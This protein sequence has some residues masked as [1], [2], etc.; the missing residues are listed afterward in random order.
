MARMIPPRILPDCSSLG[1]QEIFRRLKDDP[2][3]N[4][5]IVLHSLDVA[6]HMTSIA[7]EIDF[8]AIVPGKGVLCV[9]VKGCKSLRRHDGLWY[10]GKAPS[11]DARG[12]FKQASTAMHSIR[13]KLAK[14]RRTW[15]KFHFGRQ[16]FSLT[17]NSRMSP[18]SGIGGK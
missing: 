10:Y 5:W 15:G 16:L 9:E 12:P 18:K 2:E 11:P 7:G 1:E 17:W 3:T 8:V 14:R 6:E 13:T 4:D